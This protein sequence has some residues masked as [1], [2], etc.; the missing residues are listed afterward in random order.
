MDTLEKNS[1][2]SRVLIP[3]LQRNTPH[4][5]ILYALTTEKAARCMEQF[6]TLV[7]YVEKTSTK[8]EI[9]DAV[10]KLYGFKV[11]KVN[12]LINKHGKKAYVRFVEE[13]AAL[14]IAS[15]IGAI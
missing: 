3:K 15:K 8:P 10:T 5:I 13:G 12:T 2:H 7:F 9:R 14:E 1:N 11:K 6:N 4:D